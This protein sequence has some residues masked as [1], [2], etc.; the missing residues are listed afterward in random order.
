[1]PQL[2]TV[3]FL[4]NEMVEIVYKNK[5]FVVVNKEVGTPSQS[6]V[7]GDAD[8]MSATGE[9]LKGLGETPDLWLIHR[10]D[11]VV[12]GL[13]VF[14]R[15]KESA[16]AL[17][18]IVADSLMEKEYIAVIEGEAQGGEMCDFLYKDSRQGKS[19]VVSGERRG[20]KR[21]RLEY[22]SLFA[23]ECERGVKTL[24]KILLH[25]G[26]HH[27]IRVQFSSR[28]MALVGDGKYGSRDNKAKTPSL[29]ASRLAFSLGGEKYNFCALPDIKKYPWS[30]FSEECYK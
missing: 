26:R 27:Q 20:A 5:D 10:L 16:A 8:A 29:F 30:L 2:I 15:N 21:A 3:A 4:N 18:K 28:G 13:L 17:S 19:F 7:S 23:I 1:M 12:G 22:T 9:M 6:D 25:T 14:A 11:R 24:V